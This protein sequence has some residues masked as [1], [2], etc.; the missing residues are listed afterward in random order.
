MVVLYDFLFLARADDVLVEDLEKKLTGIADLMGMQVSSKVNEEL[1]KNPEADLTE[2]FKEIFDEVATPVA[3]SQQGVRLCLF[4]VESN[5]I[6]IKGYI[7]YWGRQLTQ[8]EE[9][10]REG[11]IRN[12]AATGINAVVT[13]GI[14]ITRVGKTWDD[15]F[16]EC[17]VPV[18]VGGKLVAVAW[19]EERMHP[20]FA[21]TA[22]ARLVIRYVTVF[23]FVFGIVVTLL[24]SLGQM[25]RVELIKDGLLALEKDFDCKL[26]EMPGEMGEI[27]RAINKMAQGLAEKEQLED[28][29]RRTE[30]LAALGRLVTDIA[31][32]LRNPIS[33][34]QAASELA[35]SNIKDVPW[36]EEYAKVIEEQ[37]ERHDKLITELLE[38]GRSS[39][40][41][42]EE[43][44][45]LNELVEG[46]IK[47]SEPLIQKYNVAHTFVPEPEIPSIQGN[48]AKLKQVFI[49]LIQNAIQAMPNG[50]NL[51]IE[52]HYRDHNVYVLI[53][54][55]G[56]G[57]SREDLPRIFQPFYTRKA[58]GS[59]LGLAISKEIVQIHRG[60]IE[61]ESEP[62]KGTTFTVG[63]PVVNWH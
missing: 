25:R 57:I 53:R 32:E 29:L 63:F 11:R 37:I 6:F 31:H 1:A 13:G 22:R 58:G 23:V 8:E 62:N 56:Q 24:A 45:N 51:Y 54:D 30:D 44:L 46:V 14:P 35:S 3:N 5:Q 49:N 55:T 19:A 48:R 20:I 10:V 47:T 61:V 28:R 27:C 38:F 15:Q 26:P 40:E 18:R 60:S 21:Q 36:M 34:I 12:E 33:V 4:V 17:L 43:S 39:Q 52:T 2:T 7:H 9:R 16:L 42:T 50:G 41:G 59:G